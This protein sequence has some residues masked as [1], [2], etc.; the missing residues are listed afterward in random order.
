[1]KKI[2]DVLIVGAGPAGLAC[3][4]ELKNSR[5]SV[6]LLE[7][8][9]TIGPKVCAGGLT[10]LDAEFDLPKTK[11]RAFKTQHI[12]FN[13][14][15]F[16]LQLAFPLKT[17]SRTDLGQYQLAKLNNATN[18]DILTNT[19]VLEIHSNYIMTHN[20]RFDFQ[21]LIG[22][23]G[24]NSLV[25]KYLKLPFAQNM[26]LYYE[27]NQI[28]DRFEWH[29]NTKEWG[30]AY[31][32]IFP[33]LNHTNIGFHFNPKQISGATAKKILDQFLLENNYTFQKESFRSAPL[34]YDYQGHAFGSVF[35]L[36]DAAGLVSKA[37]GEG[38]S[39]ALTSGKEIA[40]KILNP[41]YACSTLHHHIKIMQRHTKMINR[42][43]KY[44]RM[45]S[46]FFCLFLKLM[47]SKQFQTYF[48]N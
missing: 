17:I 42:F 39:M 33:H 1:M 2:Y 19:P 18:I 9:S 27:L 40:R 14:K 23:D 38:I 32:W 34:N 7:K 6:L 5:L 36:G 4:E 46:T 13:G 21:Y 25:R 20:L 26:G 8:N 29:V 45:Q 41:N 35:L 16:K 10:R 37:T 28:S 31:L 24:S 15:E 3:A 12:F 48:G 47:K 11:S 22:A 43:D 30:S 44:P